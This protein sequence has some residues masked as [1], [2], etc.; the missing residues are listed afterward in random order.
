MATAAHTFLD[1]SASVDPTAWEYLAPGWW[2]F[3]LDPEADA[4]TVVAIHRSKVDADTP[5]NVSKGG[6][7][8][9]LSLADPDQMVLSRGE[10]FRVD[11]SL[12]TADASVWATLEEKAER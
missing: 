7:P 12:G 9:A 8:V 10:D 5:R 6:T 1:S 3:S 11:R 4:V 2:N